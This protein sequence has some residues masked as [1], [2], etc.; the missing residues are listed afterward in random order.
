MSGIEIY[1]KLL[2]VEGEDERR[3]FTALL[4]H[5]DIKDIQVLPIGGKT[6][7]HSKLKAITST[8][9]F[10][11][12]VESLV[13]VRDADSNPQSA[14]Q[15]VCTALQ[16]AGLPIP[17]KLMAFTPTKPK[18][19]IIVL[20]DGDS[21]GMLEDLCLRAV[22]NEPVM[23]CIEQYFSCLE[24]K[25]I[26]LPRNMSK[27]KIHVY[28]ASKPE[29]DKRLGEASEAGYWPWGNQVFEKIKQ[30]LRNL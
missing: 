11:K 1:S 3:F 9:Y 26:S 12:R 13:I 15:S 6:Q 21:A 5:M 17:S 20:P 8:A 2:I 18:V 27:A 4:K 10:R 19:G 24:Q 30:F 28:L 29:A 25:G 23:E 14:F 16:K 7:I 22:G